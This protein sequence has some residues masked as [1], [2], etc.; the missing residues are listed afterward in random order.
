[1]IRGPDLSQEIDPIT[2]EVIRHALAAAAEEM[3]VNLIRTAYSPNIKE[4]RD[5]S[6]ALFDAAGRLVAQAESIPVHLGAMPY[7]VAAVRETIRDLA[8]G[9]VAIVNDPFAGGAH[10]P[11]VTFVAPVFFEGRILGYAASRAHHSDIGGKNP[12]SVA[13]DATEIFQEGLRIPPIR[14]WSRGKLR[15]DVMNLVLSN[16][17]TPEERKG[18]LQAQ[19]AACVTG[20]RRMTS[21]AARHG[22]SRLVGAMSA[23]QDYSERRMREQLRRIPDGQASFEDVLDEDGAGNR[24]IRIV[25]HVAMEGDRVSVD[26]RGSSPQVDGPINAVEAVTASAVYYVLRA[27]T[28]PSIPPNDGCYRML[29]IHA[30]RGSIVHALPPAAVVGGNLET[31]QRIVDCLLGAF[32]ELC[33]ERTMAACQGTMN[34]VTIGGTDPRTENA[35]ALYETIAGGMGARPKTDGIDGIHT[36]MTNTLNTPVEALEIAYP[37]RVVRYELIADSG[38]DGMY[39]GG[40]GVR[41]DLMSIDHTS[42]VS[43][44]TDRRT[45]EPYGMDGG[46]NGACGE[47]VLIE[48]DKRETRLPG[49]VILELRPGEILSIRTPGGGGYG[50]PEKRDPVLRSRDRIENRVTG[51]QGDF[52]PEDNSPGSEP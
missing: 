8:E 34:N 48:K 39:R 41:R 43:L 21:L 4:R 49:K 47:N 46:E 13:G 20:I 6:C 38:G 30:P 16:V 45:T 1:M 19:Y 35:Y 50:L 37:L 17:R 29:R 23:V 18:D 11:D 7:S 14:L 25:V 52:D 15:N 28:D 5:C 36:H 9:D 31:S 33:P 51:W 24:R 3:N 12:G 44:L 22:A 2:L 32:H 10:L 42:K 27:V 26:F 40:M